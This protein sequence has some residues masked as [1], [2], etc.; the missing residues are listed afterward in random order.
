MEVIRVST[1]PQRAGAYYVRIRAMAAKHHIS[2]EEE[3]DEHDWTDARHILILDDILPVATGRML[4]GSEGTAQFGRIVV[5]PEY[6]HQ[7]L[8]SLV[9]RELEAWAKELGYRN[10]F[11]E[12]RSNKVDF[13]RQLGYAGDREIFSPPFH[14]VH[15]E[16]EL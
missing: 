8:G 16:K 11:V 12:A 7:G 1:E 3:I 2:L 15:M 14:C 9:I 4:P 10:V 5:L 13:Y 6:R